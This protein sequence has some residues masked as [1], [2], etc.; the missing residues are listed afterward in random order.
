MAMRGC[1][2]VYKQWRSMNCRRARA[3][4]TEAAGEALR[5]DIKRAARQDKRAWLLEGTGADRSDKDRWKAIRDL[6]HEYALSDWE[7]TDCNR[8]AVPRQQKAAEAATCLATQHWGGSGDEDEAPSA[9]DGPWVQGAQDRWYDTADISMDKINRALARMAKS[10]SP[11]PD[12][13]PAEVLQALDGDSRERLRRTLDKWYRTNMIPAEATQ[14]E[15]V[16]LLKRVTP[17]YFRITGRI[18]F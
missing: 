5:K 6:K 3:R 18:H 14:A 17:I 2:G 8:A 7:R 16:T 11:G 1:R 15:V 13:I 12:T 4:S 9:A 10:K